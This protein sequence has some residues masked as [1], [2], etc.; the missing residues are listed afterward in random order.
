[1]FAASPYC[2]TS[3]SVTFGPPPPIQK[4]GCGL[5]APFG[6]LIGASIE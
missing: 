3:F 4:L 2:A 6:S 1:M 5:R